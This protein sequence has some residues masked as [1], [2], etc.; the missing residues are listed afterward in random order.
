MFLLEK[1]ARNDALM[2]VHHYDPYGK[3]SMVR[4]SQSDLVSEQSVD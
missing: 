3:R 4:M 1:V 2:N